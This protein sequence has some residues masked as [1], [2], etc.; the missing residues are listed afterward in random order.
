M[1]RQLLHHEIVR[2]IGRGGMGVVYEARDTRLGRPVAIKVLP[3]DKVADPERKRR[4]IQEARAASALNHPNIITV[5][6]INEDD[7]VDFIVMEY[8]DG[9]TLDEL[10]PSNGL[11]SSLALKYAIQIADAL[12]KAHDAG[13]L[14]R[15]LKPS[16]LMVTTEGRVKVLDFGLAKLT[17]RSASSPD[18]ATFSANPV[19]GDGLVMGTAPYMSPEQAHGRKLDSRSDIFSFGSVL[20]EMITGQK[21]F[22]GDSHL[23]VVAKIL[24]EDPKPATQLVPSI[25]PD[26]AKI[27][28]HC[29][30]RDPARRYQHMADVKVALEDVQEESASGP[31]APVARTLFRRPWAWVTLLSVV[32]V[33][34]FFTWRQFRAHDASEPSRV[35]PLTTFP[36]AETYPTLSPDGN[37]VAFTWSGPKQDNDDLYVQLI[38]SGGPLRLTSDPAS[39]YSAAWSPDGRWI[40]FLRGDSQGNNELRLIPPLG[41][42]ERRLAEIQVRHSYV[43]PPYLAWFPDSK[44]LIVTDSAGQD[45]PDALFVVSVETGEKRPLTHPEP[46][47]LGDTMPAVSPDGH[48][49]VFRRVPSAAGGELHWLALGEGLTAA[50][51]PRKLTHAPL[52][53]VDPTWSPD[54]KEIIYSTQGTLWKVGV[55]GTRPAVRLPFVGEDAS[56]PTVPRS[57]PD[58]PVRLVYVRSSFDLNVW[59]LNTPAPGRPASSSQVVSFSSTRSDYNPAFS[60]E[61][62]RVAFGSNRS[63]SMEIWLA[64]LDASNAVQLTS[65]SAPATGTPRWSPDGQTIAFDSNLEGQFEIYTVPASGGK[66]RRLTSHPANDHV[67]SFSRDGKWIYFSSNRSGDHQIWKVPSSGGDAVQVTHN[68]GYVAF[69]STDGVHVYYTQTS[70]TPSIL[71]RISTRGGE[72][73]KVLEGVIQRA[74]TV[75]DNGVYYIERRPEH[76][77]GLPI[78]FTAGRGFVTDNSGRLRFFDF[79]AGMSRTVADLGARV[80]LGLTA[81]PDGR[82]VLFSIVDSAT[83]DLMLVENFR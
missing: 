49:L 33:G 81:S 40:A 55:S 26:L 71:W 24:H 52:N 42:L 58:K 23:S 12:A 35:V 82:T 77:V 6:D 79:A 73:V 29:L 15:D 28:S 56:M 37:Q 1:N 72:P 32:L 10:I 5:H 22:T 21:P 16:N 46:P 54:G 11:R 69:E 62:R 9:K 66:P 27:V 60:P 7:G 64:D 50:G 57:Q 41:G 61:G 17:D 19:T 43:D 53:A 78:L 45:K 47:L 68:G 75:Q 74:F 48:S 34:G 2:E 18:D 65:M 8:V 70:Q 14:H 83:N 67:P 39:D 38:D 59:R 20:Y 80:A 63:G 13:I 51:T 36:G 30:R 3:P 44:S 76:E 25:P 31:Q 4:F